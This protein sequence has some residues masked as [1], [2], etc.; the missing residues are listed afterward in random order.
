MNTVDQQ[1]SDEQLIFAIGGG[2]Q[3]A[4]TLLLTRHQDYIFNISLKMLNDVDDAHDATQEIL[5]KLMTKLSTFDGQKA[6]FTTWLYRIIVNHILNFRRSPWEKAGVT[7]E[8]FFEFMENIPDTTLSEDEEVAMGVT[9]EEAKITCTSGML[10]C[11][12][13]EQRLLYIIGDIFKIDQQVAAEAFGL[14]P[15][16]FRKKLSRVRKDL[17]HWVH[18]RCG[19]VNKDNPCRCKSKTKKLIEAGEVDPIN[20]KWLS[21]YQEKIQDVTEQSMAS[22]E[23]AK[24][25]VYDAIYQSHPYKNLG[26]GNKILD[27]ILGHAEFSQMMKLN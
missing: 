4:L 26:E 17:Q 27:A 14:T 7:F 15:D 5:I 3:T 6:K 11:L 16:N 25:E 22:F 19:L 24:D 10:M 18:N 23:S 9:I 21:G 20:M 12:N 1:S 8:N 13:R 2:N